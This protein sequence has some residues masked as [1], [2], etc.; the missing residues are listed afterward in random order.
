MESVGSGLAAIDWHDDRADVYLSRPDKR[1]A[2]TVPL[3][4]DLITAFERVDADED[5]R[6]ATL[7]GEGPVFCAGM[8]LE[9]MRDRVE[10]D[11]EIDR[12]KFPEVLET[13]EETRQPVVV[14]IK[15]AAPA[16]AFELTLPCDF[17][18]IGR[19]A[20]YGLLEVQLGT[21]P[22]AGGTQRLPR[23]VGL[24]K[25]K[26]IVLTGEFIDPEEAADIGLTHEVVDTDDVD[27]RA[28]AFADDLCENAP[29]GLRN[30][31]KALNAALETPLEQ[32]LA[33]ERQLAY[34][35]DDTHDYREGFEARLEGR[36]PEFR[37]E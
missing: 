7:L 27:E 32:G 30:A 14:G 12:N 8:D 24:S 31:K 13:I 19:N 20:K 9:M 5:I 36:E 35:I 6:A 34:E 18:I 1:N 21:F 37:G 3:M 17:R 4:D 2:M 22:H 15:R 16:G 29:L 33:Y 28:K 26:E 11:A 23:L 25:A 10:P